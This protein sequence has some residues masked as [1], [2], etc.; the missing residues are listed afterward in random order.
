MDAEELPRFGGGVRLLSRFRGLFAGNRKTPSRAIPRA[1]R[2]AAGPPNGRS[3]F[4][5]VRPRASQSG[6]R[7]SEPGLN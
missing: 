2:T 7:A 4:D 6:E 3:R 1:Y 5:E